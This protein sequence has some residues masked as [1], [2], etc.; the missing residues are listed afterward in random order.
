MNALARILQRHPSIVRHLRAESG[1]RVPLDDFYG[2]LAEVWSSEEAWPGEFKLV[3]RIYRQGSIEYSAL[4]AFAGAFV[5]R[6][7]TDH[8]HRA[9]RQAHE[10]DRYEPAEWVTFVQVTSGWGITLP[11]DSYPVRRVSL[12]TTMGG[13]ARGRSYA[14]VSIDMVRGSDPAVATTV[15]VGH[16][17]FPVKARCDPG[18]CG[19]CQLVKRV[20]GAARPH[21]PLSPR[22]HVIVTGTDTAAWIEALSTLAIGV[23]GVVI[24]CFQFWAN[25]FRIKGLAEI[26]ISK[27]ALRLR[28][29]NRGRGS[30]IITRAAVTSPRGIEHPGYRVVGFENGFT[31][32]L[33]PGKSSM[34]LI[35][36]VLDGHTFDD[37]NRIM[38]EWGTTTRTFSPQPVDVGLYGLHSIL[39]YPGPPSLG[40]NGA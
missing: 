5:V 30:G 20:T 12:F 23:L 40:P 3:D 6:V 21:L 7:D 9:L 39:P 15:S 14:R 36:E 13:V 16:C 10:L 37:N 27:D 31:P 32:V 26:E 1:Q 33:L 38:V 35:F 19:Q 11:Q 4:E 17:S 24:T 28:L 22:R 25:G 34:A 2:D 18:E 8:W 29:T